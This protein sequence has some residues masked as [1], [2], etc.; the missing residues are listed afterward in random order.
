LRVVEAELV[1]QRGRDRLT[2]RLFGKAV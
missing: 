1:H 2:E